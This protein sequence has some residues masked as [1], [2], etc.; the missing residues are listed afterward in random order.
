[1][2]GSI[3]ESVKKQLSCK[4]GECNLSFVSSDTDSPDP[5]NTKQIRQKKLTFNNKL[6][7]PFGSVLRRAECCKSA[8]NKTSRYMTD[9]EDAATEK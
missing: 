9:Y 3:Y 2:A 6:K 1:M 7:T 4:C 5:S 8:F